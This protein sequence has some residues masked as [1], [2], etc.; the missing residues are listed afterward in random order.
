MYVSS[1]IKETICVKQ[2]GG[3]GHKA[4]GL[5]TVDE[6]GG[7]GRCK[8]GTAL[9]M[10]RWWSGPVYEPSRWPLDVKQMRK[11]G[12]QGWNCAVHEPKVHWACLQTEQVG[13]GCKM[14]GAGCC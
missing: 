2:A 13:I 9:Y 1:V 6:T 3:V 14:M 10:N 11:G 5:G 7:K 12:V 4:T 8:D